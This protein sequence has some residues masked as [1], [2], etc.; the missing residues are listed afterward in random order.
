MS[1]LHAYTFNNMASLKADAPD[2]TQQNVQ[3][4]RFG[5]YSVANYFSGYSTTSPVK[6]ASEIPG[7]VVKNGYNH[8]GSSVIDIESQIFNKIG[9]ERGN[10]K[11]QLFARPFATVPYL[12]RGGGDP[13][14]ESQ[15]Q[16]G[17]NIR[18]LKSVATVSE[19]PYIDYQ[20]YP[21]RDDLRSQIT[22][23]AYSVE[24][25]AM[26]GWTR[27]GASARENGVR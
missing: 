10:E 23:P 17:Q 22:N 20:N 11:V 13:T 19:K 4:T 9:S 6:F 15:L 24:E 7:F 16:Q 14:L 26:N 5:N 18:D 1:S 8:A 2:Q 21:I 27:G 3:N 12:G 25:V